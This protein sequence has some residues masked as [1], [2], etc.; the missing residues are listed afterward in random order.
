MR[1]EV[2]HP[3]DL[4]PDLTQCWRALQAHGSPYLTPEWAFLVGRERGDARI[5][6]IEDGG[7][8]HGFLG[9]Q[10]QSRFA[11]MGLGAPI[12]DYQGLIGSPDLNVS[13]RDL[14]AALKVGRIDLSHVPQG[15]DWFAR[16]EAGADGSWIA[17]TSGGL[18]AYRASQKDRRKD[19][20]KS[21]DKKLRKLTREKGEPMFIARSHNRGHFA[22]MLAWKQQQLKRSGQPAIWRTPWVARVAHATFEADWVHLSGAFFTVTIDRELVAASYF[23]RS[24]NVL[25]DWIIAHNPAYESYSPG[26]LLARFAVEWAAEHGVDEVDFGPGEYQYK[27]QLSSGQR[28]LS[29]GTASGPSLSGLVRR[30]AYAT[31]ARV[32]RVR[33]T[34]L[35][36]LP[37]KAMRRVDVMRG[38]AQPAEG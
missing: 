7:A 24:Q 9:V 33:N 12:A 15:Q 26:V 10:R 35:A 6:V 17:D 18:E 29:W 28:M 30:A 32:E 36:G 14:C 16:H 5:A 3:R 4:G 21:T 1:I 19:F 22:Q 20:V 8:V 13:A 25:H 27:R 31:R 23:L 11:A 37:G 34:Q 2:I 38:L